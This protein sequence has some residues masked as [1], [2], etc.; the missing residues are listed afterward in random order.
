[1]TEPKRSRRRIAGAAGLLAAGA[2]TGG[3]LASTLSAAAASSPSPSPT[4]SSAAPRHA[5]FCPGRGDEHSV[6]SS[7]ASTLRSKALAAVPGGTIVRIETDAGDAAYEAHM[8][9]ADGTPVSVKFDKN[10]NVI[11]V[12]NGMGQ[13]DPHPARGMGGPPPDGPGATG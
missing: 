3:V 8:R 1:M 9:K 10:Y 5:G 12:E 4:N 2:I 13:G 6:S 7:V 11:R